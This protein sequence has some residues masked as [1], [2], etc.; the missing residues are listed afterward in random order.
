MSFEVD[1]KDA[2]IRRIFDSLASPVPSSESIVRS[3]ERFE[4]ADKNEGL[5]VYELLVKNAEVD[6]NADEMD[7]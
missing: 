7:D 1:A 6:R 4:E 5:R 3:M 2:S